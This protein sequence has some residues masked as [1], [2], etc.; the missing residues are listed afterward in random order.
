[1]LMNGSVNVKQQSVRPNGA[2][3]DAASASSSP[4]RCPVCDV[5]LDVRGLPSI[6]LRVWGPQAWAK[7]PRC[8]SFFATASYDAERAVGHNRT[9]P[10]GMIETAVSLGETKVLLFDAI[11]RALRDLAPHGSRLLDI[12]CSYGTFLERARNVGY[13]V[14]GADIVPEAVEYVR[15]RG[16][17]CEKAASVADLDVPENSQD[18]ISVLDCSSYWPNHRRELRA[19]SARLRPGGLLVM[20]VADLS[21]AMQIGLWIGRLFPTAGRKLCE[22]AAC[23]SPRLRSFRVTTS[24]RARGGVQSRLHISARCPALPS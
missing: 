5:G 6:V 23:Q 20:R 1:M 4:D 13:Q 2:V 19:I 14:R 7:C 9:R 8:H 10:W 17:V 16:I 11:L 22:R 21:W 24:G 15:T 18:V 12:G 3:L